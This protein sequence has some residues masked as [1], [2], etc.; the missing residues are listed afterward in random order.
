MTGR[1][2]R[3]IEKAKRAGQGH[4]FRWWD[5][6]GDAGRDRLLRQIEEI[7][8]DL[9][10]RL[11]AEHIEAEETPE[12]GRYLEPA[13]IIPVP[14]TPEERAGAQEA[15]ERGEQ[16]L[17][18]GKVAAMVVAGGQGTR[19]GYDGP[20]GTFPITPI[21]NKPLFQLFAERILAHSRRYGKVIPWYIMTSITNDAD[22]RE[23][24]R[25]N[26][27]FGLDPEHVKFFTQGMMPAVDRDGRLILDEKD[28]V[29]VSPDGH[30]GSLFAL[31]RT[32]MI[33][34]MKRRGIEVISYFQVDNV[35]IK[36]A[37]PV[38]I[39]HHV[40]KGADMSSKVVPKRDPE[41]GLGVIGLLNGRVS[42]IEYSDLS[43]EEM[44]ATVEG[45]KLKYSAGSIA[46]HLINVN[47]VDRITSSGLALPYHRANKAVPY[48]DETGKQVTPGEK[49]GVKFE[50]FVFD[51]LG[52]A[53][54]AV[55]MEVRREDEFAP[56]KNAE[57]NDSPAT[58]KAALVNMWG[59]WLREAG[60]DIPV[61]EEGN[62]RG[63]IEI[64]PLFAV[65][66]QDLKEKLA[67]R[68]IQFDNELLLEVE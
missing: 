21:K 5:E 52:L 32:G 7:D 25:A 42:V 51:A 43:K 46:I 15:G 58:A 29:F 34:D 12:E 35:L 39:G 47:F 50:M 22:T 1:E 59:R 10:A 68:K 24:F 45:G 54:E 48:V 28:H 62:V 3:L 2:R 19:L 64:S 26:R 11:V 27:Y 44:Y 14:S 49:N 16:V 36:I 33:D 56:V 61:D 60:V 38:F 63:V 4:V 40:G 65:A 17:R 67:D 66:P 30:G 53:R 20:K 9:L 13:P 55:T 23:F 57:G 18:E 8:F 6:L 37:D 31:K 41:E